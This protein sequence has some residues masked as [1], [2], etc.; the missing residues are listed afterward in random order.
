M[1]FEKISGLD[2]IDNKILKMLRNDARIAYAEIGKEL[3]LARQT[4]KNR[5]D[6][7]EERGIIR[8]YTTLMD[9]TADT[10]AILFFIDIETHP[11]YF[12]DVI[13]YL[14]KDT[15]VKRLYQMTGACRLHVMAVA[16]NHRQLQSYVDML[17]TKLMGIRYITYSVS[18]STLKDSGGSIKPHS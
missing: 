4:V 13:D 3:N 6:A 15:V 12:N 1:G 8:G 10:E 7:L 14:Q 17:R 9:A 2:D 18:L 11:E 16:S 5:I